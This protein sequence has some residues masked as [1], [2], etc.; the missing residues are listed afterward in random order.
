MAAFNSLEHVVAGETG[1]QKHWLA[2]REAARAPAPAFTIALTREAGA[3]GASVAHEVGRRLGWQVYGHEL[4]ERI[5]EEH[6]LRVG[7]LESLDERRQS[8]LVE[9]M[10]GFAHGATISE[11]GYVHHL[12]ETLLALGAHGCCVIVGRG[13]AQL[14]PPATTL[15]VRLI[16][17]LEDRVAHAMRHRNISKREAEKW[18]ETT[19]RERTA[20]IKDHFLKDPTDQRQY[21]LILNISRWS[22]MECADLIVDALGRLTSRAAR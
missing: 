14:L 22:V 21:D 15:R 4:L 3:P 5:A 16:G 12:R 10:Q 18:V 11:S 6:N 17:A 19:D 2:Q 7:L 9:T 20:F 8:W 13:A 1:A